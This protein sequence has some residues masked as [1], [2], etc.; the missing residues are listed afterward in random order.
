MPF[1]SELDYLEHRLSVMG[2]WLSVNAIALAVTNK[3]SNILRPSPCF[4][5][6]I[7]GI[8]VNENVVV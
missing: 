1:H 8:A 5:T 3:R 7:L 6:S 2:I 4:A